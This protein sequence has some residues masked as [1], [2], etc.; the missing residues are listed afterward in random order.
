MFTLIRTSRLRHLE[1]LI[2]NMET[3]IVAAIDDLTAAVATL[4]D[5]VNSG[6]AEIQAEAAT[7][8]AS[9]G[10]AG[11]N[12]PAIEAAVANIN[13]LAQNLKDAV[14]ATTPAVPPAA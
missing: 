2:I 13:T 11:A 8:A 10:S 7:I 4:T 3:N 14:A 1:F 5:A 6:V 12:D 9:V